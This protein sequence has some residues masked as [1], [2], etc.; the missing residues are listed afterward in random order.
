MLLVPAGIPPFCIPARHDIAGRIF[1]QIQQRSSLACDDVSGSLAGRAFLFRGALTI[2]P[3]IPELGSAPFH[4]ALTFTANNLFSLTGGACLFAFLYHCL[5]LLVP[6][7]VVIFCR[8]KNR[9][10]SNHT[11]CIVVRFSNREPDNRAIFNKMA[12]LEA[13][14]AIHNNTGMVAAGKI[15]TVPNGSEQIR[16]KEHHSL[17]GLGHVFFYPGVSACTITENA[18]CQG[19]FSNKNLPYSRHVILQIS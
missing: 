18:R 3:F 13:W 14:A 19:A 8:Y 5:R 4:A 11:V 15:G 1:R 16:L 12:L 2:L 7:R 17:L 10:P 9:R 6:L